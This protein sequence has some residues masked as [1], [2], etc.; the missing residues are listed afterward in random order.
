[1]ETNEFREELIRARA[2]AEVVAEDLARIDFGSEELGMRTDGELN[3]LEARLIT[4]GIKEN[5]CVS[6]WW[7]INESTYYYILHGSKQ[8]I[9]LPPMNFIEFLENATR[10]FDATKQNHPKWGDYVKRIGGLDLVQV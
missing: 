10:T 9:I 7:N 3:P 1:M 2:W 4:V 6:I 5:D 8:K